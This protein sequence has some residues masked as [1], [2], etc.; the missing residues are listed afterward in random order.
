MDKNVND[1]NALSGSGENDSGSLV[2]DSGRFQAFIRPGGRLHVK[3]RENNPTDKLETESLPA[4]EAS[5]SSSSTDLITRGNPI[6]KRYGM[7]LRRSAV[8]NDLPTSAQPVTDKQVLEFERDRLRRWEPQREVYAAIR[9][10]PLNV[11]N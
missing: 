8:G 2:L 4:T 5:T 10:H 1:N 3:S 9:L 11:L 6:N 7:L